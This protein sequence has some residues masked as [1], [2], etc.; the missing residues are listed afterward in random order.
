[1]QKLEYEHLATDQ[2]GV[3]GGAVWIKIGSRLPAMCV[4][5]GSVEGV[6]PVEDLVRRH[7]LIGYSLC[8]RHARRRKVNRYGLLASFLAIS[9][10]LIVLV[11]ARYLSV[12]FMAQIAIAFVIF[13][14]GVAGFL[15]DQAATPF[16][17]VGMDREV[18]WLAGIYVPQNKA[19]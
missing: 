12:P 13:G 11:A 7:A 16:S 18:V 1:M 19:S 14:C 6:E 8:R 17:V 4:C 15:F 2:W 5:C 3:E 10:C 9:A